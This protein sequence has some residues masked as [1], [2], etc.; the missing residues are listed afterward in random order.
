MTSPSDAQAVALDHPIP[1]QSDR[2]PWAALLALSLTSFLATAN[3]TVPA[4]L[5]PQI[6]QG[7]AVSEGWAGQFVTLCALGA[8]LAAIP[9]TALTQ[10]W[11]RRKVLLF[12]F[13]AFCVCNA[14][15]AFSSHFGLTLVVRFFVGLATGLAWS[16]LATYARRLVPARLQGRALAVVMIGVPLALSLGVPLA[17]WL[18]RMVGWRWIFGGMAGIALVLMGWVLTAVPDFPG[19]AATQRTNL[20]QIPAIP[21]VRP[22]LLVVMLWILAHYLFYTYIA[23]FLASVGLADR[24]DAVL[25]IFGLCTMAGLWVVG[26]LIDRCPRALLLFS[27]CMFAASGL[28]FGLC[29]SSAAAML[30]G[31]VLWGLSFSG[32]PTLLQTALADA[33]GKDADVAQSMLVTVFN[34][35]FAGSGLLGGVL[36]ETVGSFVFPWMLTALAFAGWFIAWRCRSRGFPSGRRRAS[37]G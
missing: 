30:A 6:A 9:L 8:G 14:F 16:E 33:A 19:R 12:A 11:P 7:L 28:V 32:A 36:L 13:G 21:G 2:L 1:E 17:A 3:E 15:T 29:G 4:G 31:V 10:G 20:R 22:V 18:G 25:L 27:L 37:E 35:S 23:P 26:W 24:L 34:L 5:L